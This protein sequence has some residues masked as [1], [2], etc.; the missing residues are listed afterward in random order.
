M[1][2][3]HSTASQA[4]GS[5][6]S[7]SRGP[8]SRRQ[9]PFQ[10]QHIT[11]S[12]NCPADA[13]PWSGG[14]G[15]PDAGRPGA[16]RGQGCRS[17]L[18][19][20]RARHCARLHWWARLR[21]PPPPQ[22]R[23][24]AAHA[25]ASLHASHHS[26]L[27]WPAPCCS[28]RLWPGRCGGVCTAAARAPM[29]R[30][31]SGRP[32]CRL[33][34]CSSKRPQRT[35][36]SGGT[37]GRGAWVEVRSCTLHRWPADAPRRCIGTPAAPAHASGACSPPTSRPPAGGAWRLAPP[38]PTPRPR[39]THQRLAHPR[40]CTHP[41]RAVTQRQSRQHAAPACLLRGC[42]ARRC[43]GRCRPRRPQEGRPVG[44]RARR[45]SRAMARCGRWCRRGPALG[46]TSTAQRR[47]RQQQR[48]LQ[49]RCLRVM[50][51]RSSRRRAHRR[52]RPRRAFTWSQLGISPTSSRRTS[53]NAAASAPRRATGEMHANPIFVPVDWAAP[54]ADDGGG[55]AAMARRTL[56]RSR[57]SRGVSFADTADG[58]DSST[59]GGRMGGSNQHSPAH[60]RRSSFLQPGVLAEAAQGQHGSTGMQM[61]SRPSEQSLLRLRAELQ[62][63]RE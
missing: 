26:A 10:S 9:S 5:R 7:P 12:R 1:A 21:H 35:R 54:A 45:R 42:R 49:Q 60:S 17:H 19:R 6:P 13:T 39:W 33:P 47:L 27:Q 32:S 52:Q 62:R 15:P 14:F 58:A 3:G 61:S 34:P 16:G 36:S 30:T 51:S 40:P 56:S 50:W 20:S 11:H 53:E 41:Q 31:R 4:V 23:H 25:H 44:A 48:W 59:H 29:Q 63:I 46:V 24:S 57:L 2:V 8:W 38:H 43:P 55:G 22:L 18:T 37:G 28:W